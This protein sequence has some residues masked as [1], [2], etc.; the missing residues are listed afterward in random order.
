MKYEVVVGNVGSVYHTNNPV[1][2]N[3]IYGEYKTDS[4]EGVGRASGESVV[5]LE[6]GEP[7]FEHIGVQDEEG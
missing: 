3:R 4:T 6:D 5:L 1:H 7:K 2:A